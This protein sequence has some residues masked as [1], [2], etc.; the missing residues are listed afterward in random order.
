[1]VGLQGGFNH[2]ALLIWRF[3][4]LVDFKVWLYDVT[5]E[6]SFQRG[7]VSVKSPYIQL[8][9]SQWKNRHFI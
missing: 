1:M 2:P 3:F 4:C 5:P 6:F 7:N 8:L 9:N